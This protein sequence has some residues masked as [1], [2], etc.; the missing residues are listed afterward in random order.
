MR[1]LRGSIWRAEGT[2]RP[3][4]AR[5]LAGS[6]FFV[7]CWRGVAFSF[8]ITAWVRVPVAVPRAVGVVAEHLVVVVR[9]CVEYLG[10][11]LVHTL[12]DGSAAPVTA[13]L[14]SRLQNKDPTSAGSP[15][16]FAD[17]SPTHCTL[18]PAREIDCPWSEP[19]I[20]QG[21]FT[22]CVFDRCVGCHRECTYKLCT[23]CT[24]NYSY[25]GLSNSPGMCVSY[26]CSINETP[27]EVDPAGVNT[28]QRSALPP[29]RFHDIHY[30]YICSVVLLLHAG[31]C[32]SH[33]RCV[34]VCTSTRKRT[35]FRPRSGSRPPPVR[36]P[37]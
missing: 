15:L 9:W 25:F 8:V 36:V 2:G 27:E 30:I 20:T 1:H 3:P 21:V 14:S 34:S 10:D 35:S 12:N 37:A 16:D 17:H 32:V 7:P 31:H 24:C 22:H 26:G 5:P 11:R 4:A 6:L 23:A 13:I 18:R 28:A 29:T 19:L 33:D